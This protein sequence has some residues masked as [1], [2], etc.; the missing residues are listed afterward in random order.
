MVARTPSLSGIYGACLGHAGFLLIAEIIARR[1]GTACA[2]FLQAQ[3]TEP[4]GLTAALG[5][6][7]GARVV[8]VPYLGPAAA[9]ARVSCLALADPDAKVTI[10]AHFNG[11]APLTERIRRDHALHTGRASE[12]ET[13]NTSSASR[14][15][16]SC[17]AGGRRQLRTDPP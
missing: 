7:P 14:P 12:A 1:S 16:S 9:A 11:N 3:V 17:T 8:Q 4:L 10:A 5:T 6:P 2:D 15:M 13:G